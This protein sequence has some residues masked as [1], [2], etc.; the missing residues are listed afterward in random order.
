MGCQIQ[1]QV[2]SMYSLFIVDD[3]IHARSGLRNW[4]GWNRNRIRVVGD[5]EDGDLALPRIL[6][7]KPDIVFTDVKMPQMDGITLAIEVQ[8]F[9]PRVKIVFVSGHDD[10]QFLKSALKIEAVDYLF[11]S[12][13]LDELEAVAKRVVNLLDQEQ[14]NRDEL[15]KRTFAY[16]S[17]LPGIRQ[18]ELANLAYGNLGNPGVA[19]SVQEHERTVRQRMAALGLDFAAD[20]DF[21]LLMIDL[22]HKQDYLNR[23]KTFEGQLRQVCE[24]ILGSVCHEE[25][26]L[27]R[28]GELLYLAW[29]QSLEESRIARLA[30]QMHRHAQQQL[31]CTITLAVSP[32]FRLLAEMPS[33]YRGVSAACGHKF[34]H[35]F[36]QTFSVIREEPVAAN[37]PTLPLPKPIHEL[38]EEIVHSI[39][40]GDLERLRTQLETQV[41]IYS[42]WPVSRIG[43]I[44]NMLNQ[45]FLQ[46]SSTLLKEDGQPS[47]V[48]DQQAVWNQMFKVETLSGM[49]DLLLDYFRRSVALQTARRMP[50]QSLV[51]GQVK[52]FI[53]GNYAR[54]ISVHDIGAAIFLSD[55]YMSQIFRQETGKT[56]TEYLTEV[57]VNH[58]I[59][60]LKDSRYKLGEIGSFVGYPSVSY[61]CRIFKRIVGC[62]PSEYRERVLYNE[63]R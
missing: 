24:S 60:M 4:E 28:S 9:L 51:V 42:K 43:E 12:V 32:A 45:T 37:L 57:R 20:A 53:A 5:A 30:D 7:L 29:L 40:I 49:Q 55:N 11:K 58:A 22:D 27:Y 50:R 56:I 25:I 23:D 31:G 59:E 44:R 33:H 39:Q 35:G 3:E 48:E 1:P 61:F 63:H 52:Q 16:E 17:S 62:T 14:V 13:D 41:Q 10:A 2:M 8:K 46:V 21:C 15:E 19:P 26:P 47:A 18:N 54:D 6:E 34:L 38:A 36:G